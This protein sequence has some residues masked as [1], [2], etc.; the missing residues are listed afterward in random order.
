MPLLP[1]SKSP[2]SEATVLRAVPAPS[3][4]YWYCQ[5]VGWTLYGVLNL[6]LFASARGFTLELLLVDLVIVVPIALLSHGVRYLIR[7]ANWLELPPMPL[8]GRLFVLNLAVSV[9]SQAIIWSLMVWVIK[10]TGNGQSFSW[11]AFMLYAVNVNILLWLWEGFYL[12]WY[13]LRRSREAE[14]NAWKLTAAV[15]EAE[16]RTLKAQINPHFMFNGLNN[17]RALVMED[18]ARARD[19]ITHLSD[20]LRYSIQLNS[21]EQV[22]LRRELEIVEHYLELEAMQ[23]EERLH[24]TLDVDPA[25]LH[26]PIPPMTLQLL[27]ENA[28]KHGLAPRPAGGSI[29]LMAQLNDG[30]VLHVTVRNTGRYEPRA[31]HEGVGVQNARER[32]GLLYGTAAHLHLANDPQ[33]PD[34]VVAHLQ[35][36]VRESPAPSAPA[37]ARSSVAVSVLPAPHL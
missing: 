5:L 15:R 31:G 21:A 1:A 12:G 16:M 30:G 36:P 22:P 9:V 6:F 23:L 13:Y 3:R 7:A 2:I 33:M 11:G 14:V 17:I 32:L 27:V 34:T 26:V 29:Q 19:M 20:L 35:L 24:Y 18:P 4:L 10:P 28:I 37:P 25:A 8:L